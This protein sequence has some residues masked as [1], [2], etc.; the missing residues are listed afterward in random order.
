MTSFVSVLRRVNVA[1]LLQVS[2][3]AK[4]LQVNALLTSQHTNNMYAAKSAER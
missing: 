3:L 1:K 4:S 2:V